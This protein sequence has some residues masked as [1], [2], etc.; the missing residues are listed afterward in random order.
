MISQSIISRLFIL[1]QEKELQI[2]VFPGTPEP[3]EFCAG[4]NT[5]SFVVNL[6]IALVVECSYYI[7]TLYIMI[8]SVNRD[9][10]LICVINLYLRIKILS[11]SLHGG[12]PP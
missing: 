6:I 12:H 4:E 3:G 5:V 2:H 7:T 1:S 11:H 10:L 8:W 9:S